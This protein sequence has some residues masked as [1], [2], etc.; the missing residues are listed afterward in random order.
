MAHI[1]QAEAFAPLRPLVMALSTAAFLFALSAW[2]IARMT[3]RNMSRSIIALANMAR[4]LSRGDFTQ[5]VSSASYREIAEL[6]QLFNDMAGQLDITLSQLRTSELPLEKKVI[7]LH[8][9]HKKYDS[10]IQTISEGF[11]QVN[12]EGC[13]LEVNPAYARLS[14]YSKAELIGM[15][16][17]DLEAQ[18]SPEQIAQHIRDVVLH[19]TDVFETRHRRKDGSLWD[20]EISVSFIN[21]EWR[22]F[23]RFF[24][25]NQ[26][27]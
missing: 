16:I 19:G 24:Q 10:V 4:A 8:E 26:C 3:G 18:E 20:V 5:R 6:S 27:T 21:D 9:R 2:L 23:R 7:E 12:T 25:G 15:R 22:I 1:D 11:W 13:L 14:G 17:A